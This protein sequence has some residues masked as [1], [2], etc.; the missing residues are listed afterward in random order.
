MPSA[1]RV[2]D[3]IEA[4]RTR[5]FPSITLWNRLEG[6]PRTQSLD[7]ALQAEVRD[8]LWMLT[9]QW[10]MG[11]FRGSDAGSPV[12]TKL[13]IDTTRL[14]KYRPGTSDTQPFDET[15]PLEAKVERRP[16]PLRIHQRVASLDLRLAMGREWL[17]LVDGIGNFRQ[18]F[19]D[20]YPVVAPDPTGVADAELVAQPHVW[21]LF[22]AVAGRAMDGG[23]LYEHLQANP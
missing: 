3:M 20:A 13:R 5:E 15:L 6:R 18:A 8:A 7:R 10:Q 1:L 22:E 14:T 4:L 17:A 9:K 23:R 11:E 19:I 2:V 16:L 21:E 12:A